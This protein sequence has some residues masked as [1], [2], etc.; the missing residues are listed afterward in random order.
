MFALFGGPAAGEFPP[1]YI[2]SLAVLVLVGIVVQP[3]FIAT[4]G[5]SAKT[6]T[7]ARIGLVSGNFLKRLC[8]VGWGLT[9][10]IALALLAGSVDLAEDP[11]LVW[12][13]ATKEIL[14]PLGLGLVGLM[15]ACLLAAMM[16]SADCYMIVTSA[17]V[18]RNLYAAYINPNASERTYVTLGRVTG[19]LIIVGGVMVSLSIFDVFE[20]F[21][22]AV[23]LPLIFAAPFWIGMWWR[24]VGRMAAWTTMAFT[25]VVFFAVPLLAPWLAP[26]LRTASAYTQT[27][28]LV[29]VTTTR[30]ATEVDVAQREAA[31][32][33]WEQRRA[34]IMEIESE[35]EREKK[36]AELGEK[37]EPLQVG[38]T[39]TRTTRRGG[40][41]IFW[42]DVKPVDG[43]PEY[44]VVE[45]RE[46]G[47][48]RTVVKR[49]QGEVR[50]EGTFRADYLVYQMLGVD[51]T[52]QSK[53]S[54]Q[55]LRLPPRLITPFVLLI[56]LSFVMPRN[57]RD[58][59]DRF[60]ARMKTRVRSD[61]ESERKAMEATYENLAEVR[62]R[63]NLLP[64]SEL[65]IQRPT[66]VD[67][68]GFLVAVGICV[69]IVLITM[70]VASIG[71]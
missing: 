62:Q 52:E 11:G 15:L 8:T 38:E 16:S 47:D 54:L 3:H 37:P 25:A 69:L 24:R 4:G 58:A 7:H 42:N 67:T 9:G 28:P 12:G 14:G 36:L 60:Y 35:E 49:L 34:S 68:I 40:Q 18:V 48:T 43:E 55:A 1:E 20:Q 50:G 21:V 22:L 64:N 39:Y 65:E 6:E 2:L 41:P 17:C 26:G 32:E 66:A 61:R 46:N 57:N 13:E 70:G 45:E 63:V 33:L 71:S 51:L 53:G 31:I 19:L 5:G 23:Q 44:E 59:L 27:T 10:L 56:L 29:E 30:P